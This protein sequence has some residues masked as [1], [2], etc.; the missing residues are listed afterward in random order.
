[1]WDARSLFNGENGV[2]VLETWTANY[3]MIKWR[4]T[5]RY[6]LTSQ[7]FHHDL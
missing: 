7:G 6:G 3:A 4:H 5:S 2:P 1:L